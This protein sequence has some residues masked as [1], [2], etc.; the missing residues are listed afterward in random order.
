MA[1][2]IP[3]LLRRPFQ[4][5]DSALSAVESERSSLAAKL[6]QVQQELG[7]AREVDE[8]ARIEAE[9][10]AGREIE[11]LQALLADREFETKVVVAEFEAKVLAREFEA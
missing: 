5:H 1:V 4:G 11:R 2:F 6:R 7:K 9:A 3:P 8:A 10:Q